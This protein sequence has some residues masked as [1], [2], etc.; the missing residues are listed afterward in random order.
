V[1]RYLVETTTWIDFSKG[2]EPSRS[3]LAALLEDPEHEVGVCDVV[4]AEF[5]SGV[6]PADRQAWQRL[7]AS[8]NYWE[9]PLHA[10]ARA[11]TDRY[12]FARRG[13]HLH[14]PD[15]L[16]AAVARAHGAILVTENAKDFPMPD[17]TLVSLR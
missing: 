13:Q 9:A 10:A 14:T 3:R 1:S 5:M 16:I 12:E 15:M 4:V 7:F 2:V 17:V 8:L 11:G 6:P